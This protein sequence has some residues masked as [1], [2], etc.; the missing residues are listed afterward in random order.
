MYMFCTEV[1]HIIVMPH[2]LYSRACGTS[3]GVM[4]TSLTDLLQDF[5]SDQSLSGCIV[6]QT[7]TD[8]STIIGF[9]RGS[10]SIPR[11]FV[12]D[13]VGGSSNGNGN[14]NSNG[15]GN[16]NGNNNGN[17]G[18]D[19]PCDDTSAAVDVEQIFPF[20]LGE[21]QCDSQPHL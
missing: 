11:G 9:C 8:D 3:S 21:E 5:G 7:V 17:G 10:A 13:E 16:G 2:L 20:M 6:H 4:H 15:N 12:S 1:V 19:P 18:P 14:G